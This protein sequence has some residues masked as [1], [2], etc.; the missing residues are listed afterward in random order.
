MTTEIILQL[1]VLPIAIGIIASFIAWF[2]P[3]EKFKP[4]IIGVRYNQVVIEE[5]ILSEG[6]KTELKRK[7][8]RHIQ[9]KNISPKFA[10]YNIFYRFEF[11]DDKGENVYFEGDIFPYMAANSGEISI[12]LITLSVNRIIPKN[13]VRGQL[14][15]IYENRYGTKKKSDTYIIEEYTIDKTSY[16]LVSKH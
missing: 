10:A 6:G 8:R 15:L 12:P 1:F 2:I 3:A 16:L 4:E 11:Y 14:Q 5:D 13:I 7:I 9:I